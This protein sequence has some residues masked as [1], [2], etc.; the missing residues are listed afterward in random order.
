MKEIPEENRLVLTQDVTVEFVVNTSHPLVDFLLTLPEEER[1]GVLLS[2][3]DEGFKLLQQKG[4]TWL[5][6]RR[7]INQ[8]ARSQS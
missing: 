7:Q 5:Q 4:G 6:V 8:E 1:Q 3:L 2:T